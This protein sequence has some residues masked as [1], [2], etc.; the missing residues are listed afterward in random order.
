MATAQR[1]RPRAVVSA[2]RHAEWQ[3]KSVLRHSV[4]AA[5][6]AIIFYIFFTII[7]S[8]LFCYVQQWL[9]MMQLTII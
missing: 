9:V 1:M 7:A 5:P 3:P 4:S 6:Q 8:E 2:L